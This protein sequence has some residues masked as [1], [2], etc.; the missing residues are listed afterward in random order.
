MNAGRVLSC[1]VIGAPWA[2]VVARALLRARRYE[3]ET[4]AIRRH[5]AM[6]RALRG[7]G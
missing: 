2:F 1:L 5:E 3:R 6:R 7:R 4:G